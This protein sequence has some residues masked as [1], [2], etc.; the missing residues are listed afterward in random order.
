MSPEI[1]AMVIA[2]AVT[3]LPQVAGPHS[4]RYGEIVTLLP[5][6]RVD[7]V[8]LRPDEIVIGVVARY[9]ATTAEVDAAVRATVHAA[10]GRV[11][12]PL[13][14]WIGDIAIPRVL[15]PGITTGRRSAR[16][17]PLPSTKVWATS[18][19]PATTAGTTP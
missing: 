17:L 1:D 3:V 4:G 13:H 7:G 19:T 9:P 12:F 16:K 14:L 11:E 2:T 10:I 15:S 18:R 8:R 6:R 5:G